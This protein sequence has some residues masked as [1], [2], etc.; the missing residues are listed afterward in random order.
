MILDWYARCMVELNFNIFIFKALP[1]PDV[2]IDEISDVVSRLVEI[3]GRL[4]TPGDRF[5][6]WAR[7]VGV[8]VGSVK[9]EAEKQDLIQELDA[10]VA[11][12]YG[13]DEDD[14]EVLYGTFHEKA[15]YSG[16]H[17]AVLEHFRRLA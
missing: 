1:I 4:A 14:L 12:L 2:Q 3:S 10:C 9:S 16:Y 17:A 8:S 7:E 13:L 15:D 11:H 6:D 5:T